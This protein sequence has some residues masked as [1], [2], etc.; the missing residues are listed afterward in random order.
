MP[1]IRAY[2]NDRERAELI[3]HVSVAGENYD[4][5]V[6]FATPRG[7]KLYTKRYLHNWVGRHR[8]AIRLERERHLFDLRKLSL[9]D[10]QK[11]LVMLEKA[12][13]R[14]EERLEAALAE[15]DDEKVVKLAEQ[16]RKQLQSVAIERGEWQQKD[17]K[18]GLE[19]LKD[20]ILANMERAALPDP[21]V[22]EGTFTEVSVEDAP[23]PV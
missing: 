9:L 5:Y 21:R 3:H 14:L 13:S 7:W 17:E 22:V 2:L 1:R 20:A 18:Q 10:R 6:A 23:P 8:Q 16:M 4:K 12:S 15:G 11:R 19:E